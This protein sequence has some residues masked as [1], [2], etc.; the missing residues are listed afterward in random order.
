MDARLA[1]LR[2]DAIAEMEE[3]KVTRRMARL[4]GRCPARGGG[5]EV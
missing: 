4:L 5:Y 3:K 1:R 2:R